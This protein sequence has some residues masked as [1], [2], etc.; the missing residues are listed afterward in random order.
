MTEKQE[1]FVQNIVKGMSQI[2]AYKNAYNAE[3]MSDNAISREACLLLKTPKI[4]QRHAELGAKTVKE[5]IL[6][7]Q[8]RMEFLSD[9]VNEKEK[10]KKAISI[11]D[12]ETK[13]VEVPADLNTKIKA[14]DTINKMQ[15]I[16]SLK[17]DGSINIKKLEDLI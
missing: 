3:K 8:E 12:G 13:F 7:A 16:Y 17:V 1:A 9:I 11:E 2:D 5:T 6:T 10:E 15:G 14:I 4:A